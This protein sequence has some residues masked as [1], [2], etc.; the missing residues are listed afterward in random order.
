MLSAEVDY[1]LW[2]ACS[3]GS[4][5]NLMYVVD[6]GLSRKGEAEKVRKTFQEHFHIKLLA[7]MQKRFLEK[8]KAWQS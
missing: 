4:G 5:D 7:L 3:Q 8:L 6:N 2:P 1:L